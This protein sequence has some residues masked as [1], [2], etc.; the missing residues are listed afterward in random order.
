[1]LQRFGGKKMWTRTWTL[2]KTLASSWIHSK[3]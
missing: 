1:M 3:N 2:K